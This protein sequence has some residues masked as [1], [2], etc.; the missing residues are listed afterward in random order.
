MTTI[1]D[2]VPHEI[3]I[4][5]A[6]RIASSA[7]QFARQTGSTRIPK[8][9]KVGTVHATSQTATVNILVDTGIAPQ[10]MVFEK[11]ADPH[12]I[13]AKNAPL[14]IFPGT[15]EFAGQIIHIQKVNHPGMAPRPFIQPAKESTRDRNRQELREA[16]GRNVRL[17]VRRMAK[18]E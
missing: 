12:V 9:I 13:Q 4:R 5:I 2:I 6:N 1:S 16:V 14:L 18:K 3:L 10:A 17:V 8:S 7:R 11:G 15:N